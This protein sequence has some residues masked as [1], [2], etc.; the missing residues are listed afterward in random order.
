M[1]I[2]YN[3]D[4]NEAQMDKILISPDGLNANCI[5]FVLYKNWYKT[6]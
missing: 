4:D 1:T 6:Q 2:I 3:R 5:T